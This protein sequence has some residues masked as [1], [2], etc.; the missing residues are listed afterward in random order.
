LHPSNVRPEA[1][2]KS[3]GNRVCCPDGISTYQRA[4]LPPLPRYDTAEH[5]TE[6]IG[7]LPRL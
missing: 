5:A 3:Q 6:P 7:L 1:N 4:V 2:S